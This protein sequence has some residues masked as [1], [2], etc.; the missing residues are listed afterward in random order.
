M[1]QSSRVLLSTCVY[2]FTVVSIIGAALFITIALPSSEHAWATSADVPPV[3]K[4]GP[5]YARMQPVDHGKPEKVVY[6][7][8]YYPHTATPPASTTRRPAPPVRTAIAP[9][10]AAPI[11]KAPVMIA[12]A[13]IAAPMAIAGAVRPRYTRPDIHQIY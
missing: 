8:P 13:T 5:G 10:N 6:S 12:P 7:P 11:M 2:L 9:A 3:K 4:I 1:S